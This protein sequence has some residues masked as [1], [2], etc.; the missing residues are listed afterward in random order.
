MLIP[1]IWAGAPYP[2]IWETEIKRHEVWI[3]DEEV[4]EVLLNGMYD[5]VVVRFS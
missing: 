1:P 3:D 5:F 2:V 4:C